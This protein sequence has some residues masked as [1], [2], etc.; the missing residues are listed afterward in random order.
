MFQVNIFLKALEPSF[1][2]NLYIIHKGVHVIS[3]NPRSESYNLHAKLPLKTLFWWVS[4]LLLIHKKVTYSEKKQIKI[5]NLKKH[6]HLSLI[7]TW[8]NNAFKGTSVNRGLPY[9]N[10]GLL[11]QTRNFLCFFVF[12]VIHLIN[13]FTVVYKYRFH[14]TLSL[15][16][17][18]CLESVFL[19]FKQIH[20]LQNLQVK[21]YCCTLSKCYKFVK[22]I[23]YHKSYI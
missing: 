1:S 17:C 9:L 14:S 6:K 7:H 15:T 10:G 20:I 16:Q 8:S 22:L 21:K 12:V 4:P 5:N 23:F 18:Q 11:N 3:C 13:F 2:W 19:E